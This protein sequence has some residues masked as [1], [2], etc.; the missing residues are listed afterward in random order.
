[1]VSK[2]LTG[3]TETDL[4][5]KLKYPPKTLEELIKRNLIKEKIKTDTIF[6]LKDI[7]FK[8]L[9]TEHITKITRDIISNDL[10]KTAEIKPYDISIT[11]P[12]VYPGKKQP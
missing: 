9:T 7:D 2:N 4:D 10:W 3:I 8:Q 12:V 5:K 11:P 6:N 1:M